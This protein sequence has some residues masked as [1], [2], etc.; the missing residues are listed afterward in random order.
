LRY[1]PVTNVGSTTNPHFEQV[2]LANDTRPCSQ[3]GR[4]ID[5]V[6]KRIQGFEF[7]FFHRGFLRKTGVLK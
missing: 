2:E 5:R 1:P 6:G 7:G 4:F 3:F